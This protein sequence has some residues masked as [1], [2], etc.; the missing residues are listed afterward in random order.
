MRYDETDQ[1]AEL[2]I[3]DLLEAAVLE[4]ALAAGRDPA[5]A[6]R[7]F[8]SS[9]VIAAGPGGTDG[10]A[11]RGMANRYSPEEDSFLRRWSGVLTTGELAEA[12]GRSAVAICSQQH[13]RGLP[14]TITHPDFVTGQQ[15]ADSLGVDGHLILALA[16]RGILPAERVEFPSGRV[17]HRMRRSGW[18]AWVLNPLNWVYLIPVIRAPHRIADEHL[19]RLIQRRAETW[20][21]P[22]G[23]PDAWWS[24]GEV[25]AYHGVSHI[26]INRYIRHGRLPAVKWNNWWVRR[27]DA[28][29][30]GFRVFRRE[31]GTLY[32]RGTPAMDGFLVL[33]MSV[34]IPS[35]HIARM[36]A[37]RLSYSGVVTRYH[38]ILQ[39]GLA[40]WLARLYDLPLRYGAGGVWTDWRDVAPR[41]PALA[42]AWERLDTGV[43]LGRFDRAVLNGVFHA[44][45]SFYQTESTALLK[46]GRGDASNE[47]LR[48]MQL[49][50]LDTIAREETR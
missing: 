43:E 31:D 3:D 7:Q 50:F 5:L 38:T 24:T 29:R 44:F 48:V 46:V 39:K 49:L 14:R 27:S 40:P 6:A 22:D 15:M 19:R 4:G 20:L 16:G 37:G 18:Y 47:T 36:M 21:A 10:T 13:L 12:L 23:R 45:L 28:T 42:R 9:R 41:F 11:E 26:D 30:P 34:G 35:S 33:A 25:A 2:D 1:A 8:G 17:I 32:L